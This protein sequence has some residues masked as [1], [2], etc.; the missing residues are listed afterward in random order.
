MGFFDKL[1]PWLLPVAAGAATLATGGAAA[2]ALAPAIGG[3]GVAALTGGPGVAALNAGAGS[4]AAPLAEQSLSE[5]LAPMLDGAS[6]AL[7]FAS[8]LTKND[9]AGTM[10]DLMAMATGAGANTK[11]PG[12]LLKSMKGPIESLSA[13]A[14]KTSEGKKKRLSELVPPPNLQAQQ[15]ASIP[16]PTTGQTEL[17]LPSRRLTADPTTMDPRDRLRGL[18]GF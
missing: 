3:P 6:R 15:S 13:R 10:L 14:E 18:R 4:V 2:P 11:D 1:P 16:P 7:G 9:E 5:S 8:K 17:S 12:A